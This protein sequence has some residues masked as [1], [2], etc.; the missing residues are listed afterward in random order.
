MKT[1]DFNK[2]TFQYEITFKFDCVSVDILRSAIDDLVLK[3]RLYASVSKDAATNQTIL[4][5][6]NGTKDDPFLQLKFAR[7]RIDL[8]AGFHVPYEAWQQWRQSMLT[9]VARF[10]TPIRLEFVSSLTE[11]IVLVVP[12]EK[13]KAEKEIPE[14]QPILAFSRRFVPEHLLKR[15]AGYSGFTDEAGSKS[16]EWWYTGNL[17]TR[18]DAITFRARWN[19]FSEAD[20]VERA[21]VAHSAD[22][23][24]LFQKFHSEF[25]LLLVNP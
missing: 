3:R 1:V 9:E 2:N 18:E 4:S 17:A 8:W 10:L 22:A 13:L 11:Q 20:T 12:Q 15:G 14:L 23:D 19:A 16:I 7:D 25:V 5:K 6:G 24:R 21:L